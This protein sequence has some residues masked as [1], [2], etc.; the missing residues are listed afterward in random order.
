MSAL[1]EKMS[2][3]KRSSEKLN[4]S[5]FFLVMSIYFYCYVLEGKKTGQWCQNQDFCVE[6]IWN[7]PQCYFERVKQ[8]HLTVNNEKDKLH[9]MLLQS[10]GI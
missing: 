8:D 1:R 10:G 4:F 3:Q 2:T 5:V 6:L 9:P 7:C